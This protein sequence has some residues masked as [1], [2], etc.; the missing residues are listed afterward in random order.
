MTGLFRADVD[1]AECPLTAMDVVGLGSAGGEVTVEGVVLHPSKRSAC[2]DVV[3]GE[4]REG[5]GVVDAV[6]SCLEGFSEGQLVL[7]TPSQKL[8]SHLFVVILLLS[9]STFPPC[10]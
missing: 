4:L 2:Y 1:G 3:L 5:A 6:V 8:S 9:F 7:I 10:G